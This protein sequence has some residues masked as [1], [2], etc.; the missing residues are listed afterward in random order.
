MKI[1]KFQPGSKLSLLNDGTLSL[2]FIGV[3]S[4]FSKKHYQTNL[5][6]IK[7]SDHLM[8]D[9]GTTAPQAL[10]EL[11]L[12]ITDI[13]TFLITHSHADHIGGLEEVM[14]VGRYVTKTK[15]SIIINEA[16]EQILWNYS[17]KGG[18]AF[19]DD[20]EGR[21]LTFTDMWH[22]IRPYLISSDPRETYETDAGSI[23]LK[24]I[25]TKHI[26]DN[27]PNWQSSFLSFGVIIDNRIL[28]TS[29]TQF[30]TDLL[31]HYNEQLNLEIIF[32]DCQFFDGGVH[33]GF[34]ELITLPKELKK[35]MILTHYGD[36][37][38]DY[39]PAVKE[40][41]FIGLAEQWR[42]YNFS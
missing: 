12:N 15:P 21:E 32:H 10:Y 23:N 27:A 22:P 37:W 38:K 42:Y 13:K 1:I 24:L 9:C 3:G 18:A 8:I 41:G 17:L 19:N 2:F 40:N 28:F 30:D 29:D 34:N 36:N 35:K 20:A 6:V 5:I 7:G 39:E 16:Y 31:T 11:G 4:A 25:R 33:A 26:P 14:L